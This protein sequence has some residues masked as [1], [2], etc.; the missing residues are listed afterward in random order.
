MIKYLRRWWKYTTAKLT[1][2]FE[3]RADPKVQLQQAITEVK[4]QHKRLKEHAANVIANQKQ[5]E[6]RL[7][8]V[9]EDM[10]KV[11]ANAQQA[12]VMADEAER[13]GDQVKAE[14]Y[15]KAAE[16]LANRLISLEREVEDL[17]AL[18]F[19]ATES[20]EQ[21]KA[22]V[23]QN[24]VALEQKLGEQEKLL[25]QIDQAAMQEQMNEA[26]RSLAET[27]GEDAPSLEEVRKKIETRYAKAKGMAELTDDSVETRMIEVEQATRNTEANARLDAMRTNLGIGPGTDDDAVPEADEPVPAEAESDRSEG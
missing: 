13:T 20:S 3:E 6:L 18:H 17:K 19:E 16:T 27:V 22:A 24:R 8:R 21:A 10:E 9:L 25:G 12:L 26:R 11:N 14:E 5:T 4:Q 15:T 23:A 1:R 7:N 2:R